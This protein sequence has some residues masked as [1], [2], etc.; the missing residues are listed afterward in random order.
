MG[1]DNSGGRAWGSGQG[2]WVLGEAGDVKICEKSKAIWGVVRMGP[3][4]LEGVWEVRGVF[5]PWPE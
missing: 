4:M 5:R 2:Q 3:G 1:T